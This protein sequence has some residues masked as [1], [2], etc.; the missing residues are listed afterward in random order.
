MANFVPLGERAGE[1]GRERGR[2]GAGGGRE[3]E[4][5]RENRNATFEHKWAGLPPP[6]PIGLISW[7]FPDPGHPTTQPTISLS[8]QPLVLSLCFFKLTHFIYLKGKPAV[9][10]R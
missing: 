4:R 10:R 5:E 2:E 1:R 6:G 9:N 7:G 8:P 3:G